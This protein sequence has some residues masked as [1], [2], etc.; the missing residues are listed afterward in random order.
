MLDRIDDEGTVLGVSSGTPIGA[1]KEDY[2]VIV[3]A[4]MA[5]GQAMALVALG[6]ALHYC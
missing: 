5:Y 1:A 4:P 3:I 2:K 6:E